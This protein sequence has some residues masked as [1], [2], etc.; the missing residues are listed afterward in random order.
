VVLAGAERGASGVDAGSKRFVARCAGGV[1]LAAS[2]VRRAVDAIDELLRSG[3]AKTSHGEV[4]AGAA[5]LRRLERAGV[6]RRGGRRWIAAHD[7]VDE[8]GLR[9]DD[10]VE[11]AELV[12]WGSASVGGTGG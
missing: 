12:A 9:G 6:A 11:E 4:A 1:H 10:V 2:R 5:C 3:R 8:V 7:G